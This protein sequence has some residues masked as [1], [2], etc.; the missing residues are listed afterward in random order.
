MPPHR[1]FD[2]ELHIKN[3]QIPPIATSTRSLAQSLVLLHEFLNDI[4]G[5]GFI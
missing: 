3:D 1:E 5:K 2:H 4:L